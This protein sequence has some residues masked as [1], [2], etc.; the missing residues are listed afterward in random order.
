MS[1]PHPAPVF[2]STAF[3]LA[4]C[5]RSASVK[6]SGDATRRHSS[7]SGYSASLHQ[8]AEAWHVPRFPCRSAAVVSPA[9]HL[10]SLS[11]NRFL[12]TAAPTMGAGAS[13]QMPVGWKDLLRNDVL[14]SSRPLDASD[15]QVL[16]LS[17][18]LWAC[19]A[20]NLGFD[21]CALA[22]TGPRSGQGR[23]PTHPPAGN[24]IHRE[25]PRDAR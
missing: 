20:V 10:H 16:M 8:S 2:V 15:V 17:L 3:F 6:S 18:H 11:C 7:C 25:R 4:R 12:C 5:A 21:C 13:S 22:V 9:A 14:G 23:D 19:G 24:G 1:I